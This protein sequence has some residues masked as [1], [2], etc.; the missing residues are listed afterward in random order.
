MPHHFPLAWPADSCR[1]RQVRPVNLLS[2]APQFIV[3]EVVDARP[4]MYA[5]LPIRD[6]GRDW[7]RT[8]SH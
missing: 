6:E 1:H 8:V 4:L 3:T 2:L 7:E 5:V